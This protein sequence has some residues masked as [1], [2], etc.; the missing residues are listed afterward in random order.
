MEYETLRNILVILLSAHIPIS[1]LIYTIPIFKEEIYHLVKKKLIVAYLISIMN[2]FLILL[3]VGDIIGMNFLFFCLV[4]STSFVCLVFLVPYIYWIT[5]KSLVDI[6]RFAKVSILNDVFPSLL[7]SRIFKLKRKDLILRRESIQRKLYIL[8]RL[9]SKAIRES[10]PAAFDEGIRVFGEIAER[11]SATEISMDESIY[12]NS[13]LKEVFESLCQIGIVCASLDYDEGL[14]RVTEYI[15][16]LIIYCLSHQ[17]NT[18][19][20]SNFVTSLTILWRRTR[21]RIS[22]SATEEIIQCLGNAALRDQRDL[23]YP[24]VIECLIGLREIGIESSRNQKEDLS[25]GIIHRVEDIGYQAQQRKKEIRQDRETELDEKILKSALRQLWVLYAAV[26]KYI[27]EARPHICQLQQE[28]LEEFGPLFL[29]MFDQAL[30][31][32]EQESFILKMMVLDF[33]KLF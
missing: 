17:K 3:L 26:N 6:V 28:A 22:D 16:N 23:T 20:Y 33:G 32:L 18:L 10:N 24:C 5:Q 19:E 9:L 11:I 31:D 25:L 14:D 21:S 30:Q 13:V 27:P 4:F 29:R 8:K 7:M 12:V 15:K 1:V 2:I